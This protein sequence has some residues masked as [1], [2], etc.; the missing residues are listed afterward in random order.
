MGIVTSVNHT[1]SHDVARL[2][3][4]MK[5]LLTEVKKHVVSKITLYLVS[6]RHI[7]VQCNGCDQWNISFLWSEDLACDCLNMYTLLSRNAG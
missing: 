4:L 1:L 6:V 3:I 5:S 7:F 2:R